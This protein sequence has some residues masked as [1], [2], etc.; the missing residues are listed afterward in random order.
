[1]KI[2]IINIHKNQ[3]NYRQANSSYQVNNMTLNAI[4]IIIINCQQSQI[5]KQFYKKLKV[6]FSYKFY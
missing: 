1:M 6:K 5:F 2:A 3:N 4:T